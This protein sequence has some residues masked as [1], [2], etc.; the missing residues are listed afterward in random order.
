MGH[1][2][3]YMVCGHLPQDAR[4]NGRRHVHSALASFLSSIIY[5]RN[6]SLAS[7]TSLDIQASMSD[8]KC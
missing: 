6:T 4:E 2:N 7:K 1:S 3:N 8:L 5:F